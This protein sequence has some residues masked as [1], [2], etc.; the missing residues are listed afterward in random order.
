MP[1]F[2]GSRNLPSY[3]AKLQAIEAEQRAIAQRIRELKRRFAQ[4]ERQ[5]KTVLR[6]IERVARRLERMSGGGVSIPADMKRK[7]EHIISREGWMEKIIEARF[8]SQAEHGPGSHK[9]ARL[10][11]STIKRKGFNR[12]L[13]DT[14]EMFFGA[15]QA[16]S[17]TYR[18]GQIPRWSVDKIG[19]DYA[20]YHQT[21]TDRMPARP[22]FNPPNEK[23]M[24]PVERRA[25]QIIRQEIRKANTPSEN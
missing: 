14:K 6:S 8:R 11:K 9:W 1:V 16:V 25:L 3:V 7:V 4:L 2:V 20:E 10:A 22:F 19:V 18:F 17:G 13:V 23:E 5:R 24:R 15:L 21:G 12:I